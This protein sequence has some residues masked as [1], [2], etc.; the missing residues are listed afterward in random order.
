M[1]Q[2]SQQDIDKRLSF[3]NPWW[4][5]DGEIA[6]SYRDLPRRSYFDPFFHLVNTREVRR[7][8]I[9]LGPRRVG[10]TVILHQTISE[11]LKQGTPGNSILFL[12]LE[13]PIYTDTG[14]E[15]FVLGFIEHFGHTRESPLTIIFDEI[16]YLKD[17]EVHLKSLV[18]S[19][20]AIRFIASG[21]AAAALRLKSRESGAGRFTEFLLPPLTFAEYLF[22]V[23]KEETLIRLEGGEFVANDIEALNREFVAYL[24]IGGYPEAVFNP[25]IRDDTTRFIKSDIID[26][27]LLRDLPQ[28]YGIRDIQELNRLFTTL[29]YNTGNEVS[30]EELS[31]SS[32]VA[33]ATLSRYLEYLEAAFLIRRVHRIDQNARHFQ[34]ATAFKIY[35]T[36]PSMRAAL[37]G[38][39]AEDDQTMG[40]IAETA[41]Y[42]QWFHDPQIIEH[43]YYARWKKGEIDIVSLDPKTQ[44]P[45]W[46]TEVKWSDRS[47]SD[48]GELGN[49]SFFKKIHPSMTLCEI[50]T[51]TYRGEGK[52]RDGTPVTFVPTSIAVYTVG[53]FLLHKK[54]LVSEVASATK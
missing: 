35:L 6:S 42:A 27:V 10:K 40:A 15:T 49:L 9:L 21:S 33:K 13:T 1:L 28:L 39:P 36:N 7:A 17:W 31:K 8:I 53:K 50:T 16:Q 51:R 12:S 2:I 11:L 45:A 24:N 43:L 38:A 23:G 5:A 4:A 20:P 22:F 46:A 19:Y 32:G 41:L 3:D 14:L 25:S 48:P 37:F 30:L 54:A 47:A 18:D 26:K 52:L 34:R 29:A 44:R